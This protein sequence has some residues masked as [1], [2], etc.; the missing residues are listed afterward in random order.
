MFHML[1]CFNLKPDTSL[2]E[3]RG[4]LTDH[5]AHLQTLDLV[6]ST[7]P[8]GRRQANTLMDTDDERNHQY[9]VIISFRY[10]AQCDRSV[11]HISGHQQPGDRIH[12]EVSAMVADQVFFGEKRRSEIIFQS[13]ESAHNGRP[14]YETGRQSSAKSRLSE[15]GPLE[16][17]APINNIQAPLLI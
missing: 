3:F 13:R 6:D 11:G 9:L 17:S 2:Y 10:R 8:I 5:T 15:P 14:Q 7:G 4:S 1:S 12:R 16:N